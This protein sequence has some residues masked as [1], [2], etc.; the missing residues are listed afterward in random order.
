M[1]SYASA[2]VEDFLAA[3]SSGE[4]TPG[5]GGAAAL[6]G[7][8][9]AALVAMVANLTLGR[10]Q[11]ASVQ[12]EMGELLDR[13]EALRDE[14]LVLV[15]RDAAAYGA[16]AACFSM[17]RT[18][19]SER[20]ARRAALQAAMKGAAEVPLRT[21][22]LCLELLGLAGAVGSRGNRSATGDAATG[23]YLALAGLNS[24]L[25]NVEINLTFI[26]DEELVADYSSRVS[27]LRMEAA[28]AYTAAMAALSSALGVAL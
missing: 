14:L 13:G 7:S 17:P 10:S 24:A 23:A 5:G 16:V 4:A 12:D 8:Q 3:L 9:A 22:A 11:Y 6:A 28:D 19:A 2:T 27:A 26:K 18:T 25:L 1:P 20:E 15:D 21:A